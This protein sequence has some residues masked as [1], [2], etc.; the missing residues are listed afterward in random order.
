MSGA[1]QITASNSNSTEPETANENPKAK[2]RSKSLTARKELIA[3]G[4]TPDPT[5]VRDLNNASP[6]TQEFCGKFPVHYCAFVY[7]PSSEVITV[8]K[9]DFVSCLYSYD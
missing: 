3:V 2:G 4:L 8:L 5:A 7:V 6:E 9:P 1:V